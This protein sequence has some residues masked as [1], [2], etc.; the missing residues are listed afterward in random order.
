[1]VPIEGDCVKENLDLSLEDQE[2]LM[3]KINIV[4]HGAASV[5]FNENIKIAFDINVNGTKHLLNLC[6]KFQDLKVM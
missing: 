2:E 6:K 4:F 5:N 3:S 1:V